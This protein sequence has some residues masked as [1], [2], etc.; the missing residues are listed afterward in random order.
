PPTKSCGPRTHLGMIDRP[1]PWLGASLIITPRTQAL[2]PFCFDRIAI[3]TI[4]GTDFHP[5]TPA[6]PKKAPASKSQ[7]GLSRVANAN[8]AV[9]AVSSPATQVRSEL[10]AKIR[11]LAPISPIESGTSAA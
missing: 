11:P 10:S 8:A 4:L 6:K 1:R 2:R 7:S 9:A 5:I 3:Q